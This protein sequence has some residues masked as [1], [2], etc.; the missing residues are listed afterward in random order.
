M[1][2][3]IP[4]VTLIEIIAKIFSLTEIGKMSPYP[5]VVIVLKDQYIAEKYY[6]SIDYS[7]YFSKYFVI[8][9]S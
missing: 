9:V 5:T 1:L 3:K 7:S 6:C 4:H 2:A 8:Q